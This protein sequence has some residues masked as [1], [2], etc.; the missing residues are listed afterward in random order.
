MAEPSAFMKRAEYCLPDGRG[1]WMM[2]SDSGP[3][4]SMMAFVF[5]PISLNAVSQSMGSNEPSSLR[6]IGCVT[7]SSEYAI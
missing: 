5:S 6:R 7:R 2:A 4:F 1:S 3:F